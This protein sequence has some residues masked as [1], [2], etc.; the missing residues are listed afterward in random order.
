MVTVPVEEKLPVTL[1]GLRE[2]EVTAGGFNVRIA[3]ADPLKVPVI[4]AGVK[5]L[6]EIVVTVNVAV[7]EP[8]ATVT[9]DGTNA[10]ALL[11]DSETTAPPGSA[12]RARVTVP[13]ELAIPPITEVGFK[14]SVEICSGLTVSVAFTDPFTVCAESTNFALM[15]A[16]LP[17]ATSVV[18][19]VKVAVVAPGNTVTL[20]GTDATAGLLLESVMGIPPAGAPVFSVTVPVELFRP[21]M[22]VD[23]FNVSAVTEG[24][25]I[26]STAFAVPFA[27]PVILALVATFT[28]FVVTVKFAVVSPANTV[29]FAGTEAAAL[30][31]ESVTRTPLV[32]AGPV[33]VTVPPELLRPPTAVVGFN[34]T[35][36]SAGGFT[37]IC[38]DA[39]VPLPL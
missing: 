17:V 23:G 16:L 5:E 20:L 36:L 25:L 21:P 11:L 18:V 39:S 38:A 29:T 32:G 10:D 28:A 13:V 12:G 15:M 24:G 8:A 2:I 26:V 31:L 30:L 37:L 33:K 22:R 35:D 6:T 27:V 14:V 1:V 9:D 4:V 3:L 7:V 34:T 19:T